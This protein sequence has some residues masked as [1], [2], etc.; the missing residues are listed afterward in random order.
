MSS[1]KKKESF[2]NPESDKIERIK[3][4]KM[5]EEQKTALLKEL[6]VIEENSD[7]GGVSFVVYAKIKKL[8]S[9][10]TKALAASKR[11]KNVRLASIEEW[12]LIVKDF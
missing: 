11:V 8:S 7:E 12:D 2:V 6:G 1:G 10:M 5:P 9:S 4:S 3:N